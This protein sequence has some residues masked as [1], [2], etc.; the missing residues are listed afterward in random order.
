MT[1]QK[2][3]DRALSWAE[4][5]NVVRSNKLEVF[6][7]S[8]DQIEEYHKF[9]LQLL[10]QG[11]SVF[12]HLVINSLQWCDESEVEGLE[13]R[14]V[15]IPLSGADLFENVSNLKIIRN[16][17]P[18]YFESDITHLC[19]WSKETIPSDPQSAMGDISVE[20]RAKVDRYVDYKFVKQLKIPKED[21]V[22]FRNWEALQSVKEISHIHVLVRNVTKEQLEQA[23][24]SPL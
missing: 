11:T 22:W 14:E 21:V 10:A 4:I 8:K 15:K 17:F 18:Y 3:S 20:T 2:F 16:D 23:L 12:K 9:K 1:V 19:V 7:R 24:L 5:K 6:A 13:D